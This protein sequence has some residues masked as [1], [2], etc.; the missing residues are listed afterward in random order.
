MAKVFLPDDL[1][2][3]FA[4]GVTEHEF[5]VKD[6]RELMRGLDA[7]FPGIGARLERGTAVAIDSEIYPDWLSQPIGPDAEVRFLPAIRGG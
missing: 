4:A 7:R 6:V 2:R 3:T 5:E 1:A